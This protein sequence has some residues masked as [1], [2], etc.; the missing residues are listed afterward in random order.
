MNE[1]AERIIDENSFVVAEGSQSV[2]YCSLV[3]KNEEEKIALYNAVNS[4]EK[5]LK[6]CINMELPIRHI[7]AETCKFLSKETGE[8]I[9][10]VRL[11]LIGSDGVTY[12]SCSKGVFN[13]LTKIFK[14]FGEPKAWKNPITIIPKLKNIG[15]DKSVVY[16]EIKA[17]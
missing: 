4:P 17:K 9:P 10:G 12:S 6:D 14:L 1:V 2:S 7:Y 3:A 8:L 15:S 13:S 11:V 5:K 16:I